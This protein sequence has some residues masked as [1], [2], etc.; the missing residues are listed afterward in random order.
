V[1]EKYAFEARQAVRAWRQVEVAW[2]GGVPEGL[3]DAG[4]SGVDDVG[5]R[6]RLRD[7]FEMFTVHVRIAMDAE[8]RLRKGEKVTDPQADQKAAAARE[9]ARRRCRAQLETGCPVTCISARWGDL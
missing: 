4:L 7:L 6:M 2:P 9:D 8:A 3:L 1:T 5:D